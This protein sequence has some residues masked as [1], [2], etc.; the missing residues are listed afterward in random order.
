MINTSLAGCNVVGRLCV[1]NEKGLLLPEHIYDTELV[2]I[3]ETL[4]DSIK[5]S[6]IE[7]KLSALGN[8]IVCN[9][10]IALIHPDIDRVS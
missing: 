2:L 1:G 3:N 10:N 5:I 4:P 9:D 6:K 8:V 7:D